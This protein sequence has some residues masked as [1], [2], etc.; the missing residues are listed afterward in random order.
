[1]NPPWPSR[2][3]RRQSSGS[4]EPAFAANTR[5]RTCSTANGCA[6]RVGGLTRVHSCASPT[7][8]FSG[9]ESKHSPSVPVA[10]CWPPVRRFASVGSSLASELTPQEW[11]IASLAREGLSN[12]DIGERLFLSPRTVEWHLKK[13]F[14]K[15][16]IKSRMG[17]HDALPARGG[18]DAKRA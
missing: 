1:M 15:L 10:S 7:T 9:W 3:I 12:P 14:S 16:G 5:V 8:S 11:Q 13:V 17:L 18:R 2:S 4:G 6:A